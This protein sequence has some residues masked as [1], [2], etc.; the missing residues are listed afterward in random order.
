[1]RAGP[2]GE[3]APL[4]VVLASAIWAMLV[5]PALLAHSLLTAG[6]DVPAAVTLVALLLVFAAL[7]R[8]RVGAMVL[9]V[10]RDH[11]TRPTRDEARP[12]RPGRATDPAHH[13]LRPRAPG[14]A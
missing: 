13:P 2:Q 4:R 11:P 9:V 14:R 1:M 3:S 5:V 10:N 6:A 12:L 7:V 8:L